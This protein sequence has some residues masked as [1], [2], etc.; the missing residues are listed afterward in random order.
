[1]A[2]PPA[3]AGLRAH[4]S[5][6]AAEDQ[7]ARAYVDLGYELVE[8]RWRGAAGEIDLILRK[9]PLLVFAEVKTG[10]SYEAAV[11][12]INPRQMGRVQASAA[13]FLD[14]QPH[15]SLSEARLDVVLVFGA[16]EVEILENAYG[17][18]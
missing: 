9:G 1:M 6:A 2:K 15:G 14:Q 3:S 5:G 8:Q 13:L 7:A 12:R 4:L 17:Q 16:G 18:G 11:A 10:P